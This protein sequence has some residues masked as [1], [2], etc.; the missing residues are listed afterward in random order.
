MTGKIPGPLL[1]SSLTCCP[2]RDLRLTRDTCLSHLQECLFLSQPEA[3]G[4]EPAASVR[5]G[6][7]PGQP[8]KRRPCFPGLSLFHPGS[9]WTS[10][11]PQP[12]HLSGTLC[13]LSTNSPGGNRAWGAGGDIE[14]A[15]ASSDISQGLRGA[16][17]QRRPSVLC[18]REEKGESQD[19]HP[20]GPVA[21][22]LP[23]G[24]TVT[25]TVVPLAP[26]QYLRSQGKGWWKSHSDYTTP[27]PPS[28]ADRLVPSLEA[29]SDK[30][31]C[32]HSR[33]GLWA[34]LESRSLDSK[35]GS[36]CPHRG[37]WKSHFSPSVTQSPRP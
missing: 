35:L 9:N 2:S 11:P 4:T 16:A 31:V 32:P 26:S 19:P 18:S 15:P 23:Q 5:P 24:N 25:R 6:A 21:L 3:G 8:W 33:S 20:G 30:K 7:Q 10:H 14:P 27:T 1:S 12:S 37:T 29:C 34:C 13:T 22:Q 17:A 28:P 36:T